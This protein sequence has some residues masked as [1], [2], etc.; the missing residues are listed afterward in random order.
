MP[1]YLKRY[2]NLETF[3]MLSSFVLDDNLKRENIF[4]YILPDIR[5]C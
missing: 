5:R 2:S 1:F 3:S 4:G